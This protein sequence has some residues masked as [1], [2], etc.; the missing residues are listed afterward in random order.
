MRLDLYLQG[1]FLW[2]AGRTI[3]VYLEERADELVKN[4]SVLE[5][6]AGAGLPSLMCALHGASHTVVTDYPDAALIENL[7]YNIEHCD[8]LLKSSNLVAEVCDICNP[9][10]DVTNM[11]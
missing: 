10:L 3:S 9:L 8:I 6:G 1:H 7:Q 4:K 2:N 5:L 11:F